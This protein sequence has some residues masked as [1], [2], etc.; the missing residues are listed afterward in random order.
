V[1]TDV[2]LVRWDD[3][4]KERLSDTISRS[5]V[6][7]DRVMLAHV[8]LVRGAVVPRHQ[9]EN[10]Q[11]TYI[12]KGRLRFWIGDG[13]EEV[14]EVGDGEVLHLPSGV[15]HRAEAVED[16][17]DLDVFAPPRQD[18]LTGADAYLRG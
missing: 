8:Y 12:V 14:V 2:Q 1:S 5:I 15:P 6:S 11:F 16:T 17:I 4:P 7:G 10:E 3:L 18:W 13:D 9:H